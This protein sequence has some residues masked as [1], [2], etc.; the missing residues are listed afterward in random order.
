MNKEEQLD[1]VLAEAWKQLEDKKFKNQKDKLQIMEAIKLDST[2]TIN[3]LKKG[4]KIKIGWAV[5]ITMGLIIFLLFQMDNAEMVKLI[6]IGIISYILGT[7]AMLFSYRK[8][9]PAI[10]DKDILT[11]MKDNYKQIRGVLAAEQTWALITFI[12]AVILGI[13]IARVM[14]GESI[15]ECFTDPRVLKIMVISLFVLVP[16]MYFVSN[17]MNE[18]AFGSNLKKLEEDITKMETLS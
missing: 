2:S 9:N 1:N 16:L 12:P 17:K 6:S 10:G 11:S 7:I 4:L 8:I 15:I 13:L 18:K 5:A 3:K 14:R